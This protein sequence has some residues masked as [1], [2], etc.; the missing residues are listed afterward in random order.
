M[1]SPVEGHD[2]ELAKITGF[3]LL[4]NHGMWT[5]S[6]N[7]RFGQST[8]Q[9]F[10]NYQLSHYSQDDK[11]QIGSA[12][13]MDMLVQI[14]DAMGVEHSDMLV[15]KTV[16]VLKPG[17][18]SHKIAGLQQLETDGEGVFLVSDWKRRWFPG[19]ST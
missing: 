5:F 10:G 16:W 11:R 12:A 17:G 19:E 13:G 2:R 14:L 18:Q 9:S 3:E 4:K 8:H 7:L 1:I 6:I 15:G